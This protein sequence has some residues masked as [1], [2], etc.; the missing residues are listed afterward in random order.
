MVNA[1][2]VRLVIA[3]APEPPPPPV[4]PWPAE[5]LPPAPPAPPRLAVSVLDRSAIDPAFMTAPPPPPPPPWPVPPK[6]AGPPAPPAPPTSPLRVLLV[7]VSVAPARLKIAAPPPL[8]PL[9]VPDAAA[10]PAAPVPSRR[11]SWLIV[12]VPPL[13]SSSALVLPPDTDTPLT[14]EV[15]GL[16]VSGP[17]VVV[18]IVSG[19]RSVIVVPASGAGEHDLVVGRSA[20]GRGTDRS[21]Q[22]AGPRVRRVRDRER[23]RARGSRER[24]QGGHA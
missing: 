1:P 7:I 19:V 9:T 11:V 21:T 8:P 4:W 14:T 15:A 24:D 6:S 17:L 22:G 16:M 10:A 12:T 13:T 18:S 2:P 23:V 3:P 20:R 5:P